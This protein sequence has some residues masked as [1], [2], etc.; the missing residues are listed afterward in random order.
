MWPVLWRQLKPNFHFFFRLSRCN[1]TF[2]DSKP[3]FWRFCLRK[4][5]KQ[6]RWVSTSEKTP[7]SSGHSLAHET[8]S[9]CDHKNVC[10]MKCPS[11]W[12]FRTNFVSMSLERWPNTRSLRLSILWLGLSQR[13]SFADSSKSPFTAYRTIDS[14]E[15]CQSEVLWSM[16]LPPARLERYLEFI[17]HKVSKIV[18][19]NSMAR[20]SLADSSKSS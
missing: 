7:T 16:R 8:T 10:E 12:G 4:L 17:P 9:G 6:S 2:A 14:P 13:T 15:Y 19:F 18:K 11:L 1:C 20:I 3:M 5:S